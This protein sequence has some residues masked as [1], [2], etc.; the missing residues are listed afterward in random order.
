M[1][2]KLFRQLLSGQEGTTAIE[3]GLVAALVAVAIL[4]T[5]STFGEKLSQ[6]MAAMHEQWSQQSE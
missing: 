3:Y 6:T 4:G 1:M 2:A 5:L